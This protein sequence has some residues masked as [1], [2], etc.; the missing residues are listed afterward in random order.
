MKYAIINIIALVC[1]RSAIFHPPRSYSLC[2]LI[3]SSYSNNHVW[4]FYAIVLVCACVCVPQF[5]LLCCSIV[6]H[7]NVPRT[8]SIL[9]TYICQRKGAS[10]KAV[11]RSR[12]WVN[13]LVVMAMNE[14]E[15]LT[16]RTSQFIPPFSVCVCE[17]ACLYAFKRFYRLFAS[18]LLVGKYAYNLI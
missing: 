13:A 2:T 6:Q 1:F 11:A 17:C 7:K 16:R 15:W 9:L 12:E 4:S 18:S 14:G 8:A 3:F 10:E 5:L